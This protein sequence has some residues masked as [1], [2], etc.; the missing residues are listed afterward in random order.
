MKQVTNHMKKILTLSMMVG[1]AACDKKVNGNFALLPEEES[2]KQSV[3][4]SP[5]K[6]DILWVIDNSG[7]METSQTNVINNFQSFIQKF[8]TL[9]YD[10]QMGVT[11]TDAYRF[12]TTNQANYALL[13][14]GRYQW[15]DTIPG[16]GANYQYVSAGSTYMSGVR[17]MKK[18]TA[19]LSTV[20]L[21]NISQGID[22]S[23]DER[24]FDSMK[25]TLAHSG[26]AGF[27]RPGAYLAV[28]MVGDEDDSSSFMNESD[29]PLVSSFVTYLDSLKGSGNYS[30][31]GIF[32]QDSTCLNTLNATYSGRS[33]GVRY[34][35]LVTATGGTKTSLCDDFG[36]S[37][38]LLSDMV[39]QATNK[40]PLDRLPIVDTIVVK[41]DGSII[42]QNASTGWT[43]DAA[44]NSVN[45]TGSFI[46][47]QNASININYD[48][49]SFK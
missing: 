48:P 32:I 40:F 45:F 35:Q 41:V 4:Y 15:M 26:N 49:V 10:F 37:L 42:P 43:Y 7:S 44:A 24:P 21:K 31:S 19:N 12:T 3:D 5:R 11:T 33:I 47:A 8:Q 34:D 38:S 23:G 39:L 14:D 46:P 13:R 28:I 6:I 36:T 2:F 18:D 25:V 9:N 30:V 29:K 17:V 20:F 16:P 1:L 27:V 22:G